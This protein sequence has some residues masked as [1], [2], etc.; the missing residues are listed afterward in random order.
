MKSNII[1]DQVNSET[2]LTDKDMLAIENLLTHFS[3]ETRQRLYP[4][5]LMSMNHRGAT[6]LLARDT[7]RDGHIVGMVT[8]ITIQ[9]LLGWYGELCINAVDEDYRNQGIG[10]A[11]TTQAIEIATNS[12]ELRHVDLVILPRHIDAASLYQDLGF[13]MLAAACPEAG[14]DGMDVYRIDV[15][16]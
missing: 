5:Q 1:I 7:E 3:P 13:R 4:S 8:L 10:G 16:A 15:L 6:L 9:T 11:L 2:G 14:E 12:G